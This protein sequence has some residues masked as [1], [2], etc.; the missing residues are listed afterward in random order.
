MHK[1]ENEM[2]INVTIWNEYRHELSSEEVGK[3]YPKGIHN[4][5]KDLL[6]TQ[7]D[8]VITTATLDMEDCG[9]GNGVL[10]NTDVLIWWGHKVHDQLPDVWADRIV[11]RVHCG[12]GF[13]ALHSAH[14]SK[15]FVRLMGG[16]C[17]LCWRDE[18]KE[19]LWCVMP[20]HPIAEGVPPVITLPREEMYG[21]PFGIPTPDELI[22]IGWFSYGNVFRSGCTFYRGNGRIFYFQPG[23][24]TNPIYFR[25]DIGKIIQ[26]AVRWAKPLRRVE[27]IEA[28][29]I[30]E[31][32]E[33]G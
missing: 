28:P 9:L 6:L 13:I 30:L 5:I 1:G 2:S 21:E 18:A 17:S 27:K 26:N 25:E 20:S 24:E 10:E 14:Y 16:N 3:V 4:A 22:F 12:M 19:H 31:P 29:Q 23:H 8:F 7:E 11:E 33:K 32:L 15:P